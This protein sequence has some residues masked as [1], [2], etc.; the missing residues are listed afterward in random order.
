MDGLKVET[1]FGVLGAELEMPNDQVSSV[2]VSI[3]A[4]GQ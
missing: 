4:I 2:R 3:S 1:G